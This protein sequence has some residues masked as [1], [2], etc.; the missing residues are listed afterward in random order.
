MTPQ[1]DKRL[2]TPGPLTTSATV[3]EAMLHDVGSRDAEFVNIVREIRQQLL[4]VAGVSQADGYEGILIP[5]SGT[6][7]IESVISS[8]IPRDGKLMVIINGAYGQRILG[9]ARRHGIETV[10]IEVRENTPLDSEDVRR[11]L[12]G[13]CEITHVAMV[14]CETSSGI[15]NSLDEIGAVVKESK[16]TFIVDAMSSCLLYTSPSPRD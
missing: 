16:R 14:H 15:L 4:S 9:I 6:F 5:G 3:K 8:V 12:A 13:D 11:S 1:D 10:T 7:G 2:F